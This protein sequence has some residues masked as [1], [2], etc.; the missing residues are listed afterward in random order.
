M[1]GASSTTRTALLISIVP[2]STFTVIRFTPSESESVIVCLTSSRATIRPKSL[3]RIFVVGCAGAPAW[4]IGTSPVAHHVPAQI[5]RETSPASNSIQTP[6]PIGGIAK[7]PHA[8]PPYG[9]HGCAQPLGDSP[10]TSGTIACSRPSW[11][12]SRL[13]T[14]RPRYLP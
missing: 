11:S 13:L 7:K 1:I 12:G 14:T 5:G 3:R 10:S 2:S 8:V 4:S 6:A 9:A